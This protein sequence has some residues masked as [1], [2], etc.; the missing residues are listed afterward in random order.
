MTA[1]PMTEMQFALA[2]GEAT[3]FDATTRERIL[4]TVFADRRPGF[5]VADAEP[6]TGLDVFVRITERF[7]ALLAD[8]SA[9]DW[10][11]PSIR[12][13][14]VQQLVG[15]LIGVEAAFGEAVQGSRSPADVGHVEST[16][17]A[18][19]TQT[20]RDP[21]RTRAEWSRGV[22]ATK[23]MVADGRD[24]AG[25]VRMH[26]LTFDLDSFLV[27]R[28]FEL[29]THDEDIRRATG[30]ALVDPD[31]AVLARMT[32]LAAALLPAGVAIA[33][34]VEGGSVRLVLTG[35][36]GGAWDV[37]LDGSVERALP[38]RTYQAHVTVDAAA[39][40]RVVA[41]RSTFEDSGPI[42]TGGE[43]KARSLFVGAAA[44]AL[45]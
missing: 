11:A 26:G 15:H 18:A 29:W 23:A 2:E 36:G 33:G 34:G 32:D 8:L 16:Q 9:E 13:L 3:D 1:D 6:V 7:E 37:Q 28:A 22:A 30:R 39:F 20:G 21:A 12:G 17:A 44:L 31:P 27:V 5:P 45:D 4:G 10:R 25:P 35:A 24:L 43:D 42:V 19:S 41:N 38:G 14:D 40:C